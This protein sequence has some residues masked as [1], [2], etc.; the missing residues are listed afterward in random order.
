MINVP[1]RNK[2]IVDEL[3]LPLVSDCQI[4][5]DVSLPSASEE[6]EVANVPLLSLQGITK[7]FPGVMA[8]NAIDLEL[9]TER[10]MPY[11]ERTGPAK[12]P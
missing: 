5:E 3:D 9:N 10:C 11:W 6:A 7:R 4:I 8:N 1:W 2:R 12:A